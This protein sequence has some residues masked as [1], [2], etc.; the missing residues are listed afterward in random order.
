MS[1]S[2]E[3]L[4]TPRISC[5]IPLHNSRRFL[6]L[7]IENID[8][9]LSIGAE[10]LISDRHMLDDTIDRLDGLY[11]GVDAVRLFADND[12]ADWVANINSL[13][14]A[15]T[16][17]FLRIVPHDD[18]ATADSTSRLVDALVSQPE[19][20][21]ATGIV[22]GF[23][24]KGNHLRKMDELN[25]GESSD[26]THWDL[27][28]ALSLDF[29]RRFLGGFKGVVRAAAI[30]SAELTIRPT[31]TLVNSERL[32][33][34][35][36]A[37]VGGFVFVPES[38]LIK[39]Y[40]ADSTHRTWQVSAQTILDNAD[41]MTA[42]CEALIADPLLR[43]SAVHNVFCNSRRVA[44]WFH[45]RHGPPPRYLSLAETERRRPRRT[46]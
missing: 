11:G 17:D 10:V 41:V 22:R 37:L 39:R 25:I 9:H 3:E 30:R 6:P 15:S 32:W 21:L 20:V 43:N 19:A 16:G 40:Y 27:D 46:L 14:I 42:Y 1:P 36:L 31:P 38:V 28:D 34:F 44:R 24:L 5:L 13:L 12:G 33:L 4:R 45:T 18:T 7:I 26:A 35:G 2:R 29:H 8:S 23:D